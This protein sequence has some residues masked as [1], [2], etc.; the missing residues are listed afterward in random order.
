MIHDQNRIFIC[1]STRDRIPANHPLRIVKDIADR[2][3]KEVSRNFGRV[4]IP[5]DRSFIPPGKL[6]RALL[7]QVLYSIPTERLLL[8]QLDYNLLFRWFVGLSMDEEL[9]DDS[10]FSKNVEQLLQ[11]GIVGKF[12]ALIRDKA[13]A[14]KLLS[15]EHFAVDWA[16]IDIRASN[17]RDHS[18]MESCQSL[19][20]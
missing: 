5:T 9:W 12:F 4:R 1:H 17:C 19:D 6:L 14:L 15:D 3:L 13:E 7:L 10:T 2:D 16:L 8:E 11:T 20:S 18:G